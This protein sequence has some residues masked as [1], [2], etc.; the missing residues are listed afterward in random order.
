MEDLSHASSEI[1]EHQA[2]GRPAT[3]ETELQ[4]QLSRNTIM[5]FH[6]DDHASGPPFVFVP[7]VGTLRQIFHWNGNAPT[8]IHDFVRIPLPG[9]ELRRIV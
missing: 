6:S 8:I 1:R 4:P 3:W 2:N 7:A 5:S 9:K